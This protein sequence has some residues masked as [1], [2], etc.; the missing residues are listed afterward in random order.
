MN[1]PRLRF[2]G[3]SGEWEEQKLGDLCLT[4]KSGTG[5]TSEQINNKGKYPVYGGN[6][7]RGYADTLIIGIGNLITGG[8]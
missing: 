7:L 6:G 3:F 8:P 4:F 5:I 2:K 1:V